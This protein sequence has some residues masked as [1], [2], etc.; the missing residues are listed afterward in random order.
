MLNFVKGLP[1][2]L[3]I[4]L[5]SGHDVASSNSRF[6]WAHR[7]RICDYRFQNSLKFTNFT[8]FLK[9]VFFASPEIIK[10]L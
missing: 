3:V 1:K 10:V 5:F 2:L 6:T 9:F 7:L 8:K 4:F